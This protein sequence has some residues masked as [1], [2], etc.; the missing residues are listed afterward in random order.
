MLAELMAKFSRLGEEESEGAKN[1]GSAA[2]AAVADDSGQLSE[3]PPLRRREKLTRNG[4]VEGLRHMKY[5]E[6]NLSK[7]FVAANNAL[8]RHGRSVILEPSSTRVRFVHISDVSSHVLESGPSRSDHHPF[9]TNRHTLGTESF[10]S[11]LVMS[12]FILGTGAQI[13]VIVTTALGIQWTLPNG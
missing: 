3:Y 4:P 5:W 9:D 12:S 2:A 10:T 7:D 11:H 6:E 1:E 13:T 8:K